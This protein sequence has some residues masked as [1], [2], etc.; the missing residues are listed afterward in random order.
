MEQ[1][2]KFLG[3]VDFALFKA[4]QDWYNHVNDILVYVNDVL[5]P[6]GFENIE[7]DDFDALRQMLS[8]RR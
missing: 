4:M 8:R 6:H 3:P 7:K 2:L 5:Q 1:K